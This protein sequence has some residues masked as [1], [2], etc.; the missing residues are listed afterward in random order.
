MG[1]WQVTCQDTCP[2]IVME[3]KGLSKLT[4]AHSTTHTQTHTQ[5]HTHTQSCCSK[6][7][8]KGD[9]VIETLQSAERDP[10]L[11]W[12]D[13]QTYMQLGYHLPQHFR[14]STE[15]SYARK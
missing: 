7:A 9:A 8:C 1:L 2:Y 4:G 10:Y 14:C 15:Q 6:A 11:R 5:T 12:V 13:L 3:N